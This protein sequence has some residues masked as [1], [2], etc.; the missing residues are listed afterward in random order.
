LE[1]GASL[2]EKELVNTKMALE[3]SQEKIKSLE[4]TLQNTYK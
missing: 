1:K 4:N 2:L 3:D